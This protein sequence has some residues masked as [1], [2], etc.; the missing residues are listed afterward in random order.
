[1]NIYIHIYNPTYIYTHIL[2]SLACAPSALVAPILAYK[3]T[4]IHIYACISTLHIKICIYLFMYNY[5]PYCLRV[6]LACAACCLLSAACCP[7]DAADIAIVH[8]FCNKFLGIYRCVFM[9]NMFTLRW[10]LYL[11]LHI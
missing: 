1:M 7:L 9:Q 6:C 10:N 8:C 2:Q 3:H 5:L 11:Y 4:H